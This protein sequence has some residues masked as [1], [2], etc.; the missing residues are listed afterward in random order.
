[1]DNATIGTFGNYTVVMSFEDLKRIANQRVVERLEEAEE[2]IEFYAGM[3]EGNLTAKR[4]MERYVD[5][6]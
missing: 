3:S 6:K 2:V 1:M 5:V 4:Y